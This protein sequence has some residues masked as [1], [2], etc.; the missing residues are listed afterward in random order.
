MSNV[1]TP[2]NTPPPSRGVL[3]ALFLN[4]I[5]LVIVEVITYEQGTLRSNINTI[6]ALSLCLA[7]LCVLNLAC[8]LIAAIRG[9]TNWAKGFALSILMIALVG[10]GTCG[11]AFS[12]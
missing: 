1:S 3:I 11:Y 2:E 9:K 5:V 8:L 12:S 10:F 4:G 6:Y 7:A